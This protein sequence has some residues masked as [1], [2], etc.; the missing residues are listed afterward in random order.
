LAQAYTAIGNYDFAYE[1]FKAALEI[2]P[3]YVNTVLRQGTLNQISLLCLSMGNRVDE[4][5]GYIREALLLTTPLYTHETNFIS[6]LVEL[7]CGHYA[8][9]GD[10]LEIAHKQAVALLNHT[11]SYFEARFTVAYCLTTKLLTKST[12]LNDYNYV[13]AKI[14]WR[15]ALTSCR[16]PGAVLS[17]IRIISLLIPFDRGAIVEHVIKEVE[18]L[19]DLTTQKVNEFFDHLAIESTHQ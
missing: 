12:S 3:P 15:E 2:D 17:A 6:A 13:E 10:M 9:A 18:S 7:Y 11:P 19:T 5:A 4:A 1:K 16:G 14:A 8:I